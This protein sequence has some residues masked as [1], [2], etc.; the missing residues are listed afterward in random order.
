MSINVAI[1]NHTGRIAVRHLDP[2]TR[3][4]ITVASGTVSI[5]RGTSKIVDG[6]SVSVSGSKPYYETTWAEATYPLGTYR[7][8][9]I[10][11]DGSATQRMEDTFFEVVKRAFRCPIGISDFKDRYPFLENLVQASVGTTLDDYL[12]SAWEEIELHLYGKLERY[13]GNVFHP[14]QFRKA[15]EFWCVSDAYRNIARATGSEDESKAD[16][17]RERAMGALQSALAYARFDKDD[18]NIA[19]DGES[20]ILSTIRVGR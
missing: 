13:P 16:H 12:Q 5:Y 17:F 14:E 9:W 10:L 8:E 18:D 15:A 3:E 19:E 6:D 2:V 20:G 1:Q 7:A 11:V 4:E